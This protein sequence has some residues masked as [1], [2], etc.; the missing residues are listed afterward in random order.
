MSIE[1]LGYIGISASDLADWSSFGTQVLGMEL[2]KTDSGNLRFR[3][4]DQL[5]RIEIVPGD[6]DDIIFAGFEVSGPDSLEAARCRLRDAGINFTEGSTE[7]IQ[8]R[9]VLDLIH[10]KDPQGMTVEIYHGPSMATEQPFISPAGVRSFVTGEQ[11]MGHIFLQAQNIDELRGF[12]KKGLGFKLT[13]I[14]EI[15]PA[16]NVTADLE[17]YHCNPRHHTI[18]MAVAMTPK[19]LHHF[20]LQGTSMNDVG[21]AYDRAEACG[22]TIKATIGCHTNDQVVSFYVATPSG[23][24]VEFGFGGVT[25]H[26]AWRTTRHF[27]PSSWGHKGLAGN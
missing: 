13:D 1:C 3:Y 8:Q 2:N 9:G 15:S 16:P 24:D 20:M 22:S 19:K 4:D 5:W 18:G 23:F 6:H 14:I 11:G 12:Y 21:F 10:C 7:L 17:F 26:E 27:K 25:I